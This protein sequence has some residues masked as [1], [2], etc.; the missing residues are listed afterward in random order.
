VQVFLLFK[1]YTCLVGAMT[2]KR[3]SNGALLLAGVIVVVLARTADAG[4]PMAHVWKPKASEDLVWLSRALLQQQEAP[5][6]GH[7]G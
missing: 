7:P 5:K 3:V 2:T 6:V 4:C 1:L